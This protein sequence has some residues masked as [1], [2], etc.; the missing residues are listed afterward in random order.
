MARWQ[1]GEGRGAKGDLE[2]ARVDGGVVDPVTGVS[3]DETMAGEVME[4]SV[5][6]G[7]NQCESADSTGYHQNRS[8]GAANF[9][10]KPEVAESTGS[11][12]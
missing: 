7:D 3:K 4:E 10:F 8:G 9:Y 2:S 12:T 11:T 6:S 5:V 1:S